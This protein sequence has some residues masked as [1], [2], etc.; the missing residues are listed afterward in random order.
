MRKHQDV[1]V[2]LRGHIDFNEINLEIFTDF[3]NLASALLTMVILM[4]KENADQKKIIIN[5]NFAAVKRMKETLEDNT[6]NNYRDLIYVKNLRKVDVKIMD[7]GI[8]DR[9]SLKNNI[10]ILLKRSRVDKTN[11]KFV[12]KD[13][14]EINGIY[15][16][17]LMEVGE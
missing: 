11:L 6:T 5:H 16:N 15:R 9:K 7:L 4:R 13:D 8:E 12:T 10:P 2:L 14:I 3:E 1:S 17:V